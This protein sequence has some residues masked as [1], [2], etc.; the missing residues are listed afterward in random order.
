M[1]PSSL[2]NKLES[3]QRQALRIIYGWNC[4]IDE[5]MAVKNIETLASRREAAILNFALKNEHKE[6]YGK[7]WFR[8]A[9]REDRPRRE[10]VKYAVPFC[11]TERMK[12]NPISNMTR[13]L[14]Q[15]YSN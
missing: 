10:Q 13:V 12:A 7:R 14:N 1:I 11:R 8:E 4:D 6:R 15:H 9:R 3:I 2:A 5:V